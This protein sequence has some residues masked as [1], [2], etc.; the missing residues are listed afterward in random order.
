MGYEGYRK[1]HNACYDTASYLKKEIDKLKI[2]KF[3]YDGKN[4]IPALT[5]CIKDEYKKKL[6]YSAY[7]LSDKMRI[8]GWLL[9]AYSM[10]PNAQSV[11]A[12]R[13]LIKHGFSKDMADLFIDDLKRSIDNLEKNP[14]K[15]PST[16]SVGKFNH[17]GK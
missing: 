15:K 8:Y 13:M 11:I 5:F 2:F 14:H 4:G 12:L 3:I 16:D 17:T 1:I 6:S 9:P 10:A 7:D